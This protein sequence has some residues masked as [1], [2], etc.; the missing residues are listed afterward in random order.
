MKWLLAAISVFWMTGSLHAQDADLNQNSAGYIPVISGAIGYIYNVNGGV[1]ALS[2]QINPVLL[3][4]FGSHVLLESHVD[5]IGFFQ[6]EHLTS[7]PYTGKVYKTVE[8]AQVDWLANTHLIAVAGRFLLPF[9]LYNERL[10]PLWIHDLQDGPI[11]APIGTLPGGSGDGIM[12][13]GVLRQT[14]SYSIQYSS[15]FSTN[16]SV[17]QLE[18]ARAAG[19]DASIYL[20]NRRLEVGGSYQR[21]LQDHEINSFAT[22]ASWQPMHASLDVKF[23][24]DHSY[25][26]YGYWLQSAYLFNQTPIKPA[27]LKRMQLVGRMQQFRPL[28]GGGNSLPQVNTDRFDAG[29]NYYIRDNLRLISSYGRQFNSPENVNIWNLGFTYRFL[30]P[31]WPERKK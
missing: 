31:L 30:W 12:L 15:Y 20:T 2:P 26:G 29:L 24:Y 23:E 8:S 16:C 10:S 17:N 25:N 13:R 5:F 19:G 14:P 6:R 7:G 1:S 18:A 3:V 21:F 9:G 28:H 11:T 4:P 27:F 22:Y